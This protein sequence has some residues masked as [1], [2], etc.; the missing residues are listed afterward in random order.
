MLENEGAERDR[1]LAEKDSTF[2]GDDRCHLEEQAS[3][4]IQLLVHVLGWVGPITD[5]N[6]EG[7]L[8]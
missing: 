7:F 5:H 4:K 2:G 1:G 6:H 8:E 3:T